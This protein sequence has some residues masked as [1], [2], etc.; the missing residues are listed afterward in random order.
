MSEMKRTVRDN[1]H[2][3]YSLHDMNMIDLRSVA[4]M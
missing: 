3:P 2:T 1:I 4:M